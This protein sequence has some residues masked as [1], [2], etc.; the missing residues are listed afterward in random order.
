[1]I[2]GRTAEYRRPPRRVSRQSR[3][4]DSGLLGN[5]GGRKD[6]IAVDEINRLTWVAVGRP[7]TAWSAETTGTDT[8]TSREAR[9]VS[10]LPRVDGHRL[11]AEL[12]KTD[13]DLTV[14]ELM[15]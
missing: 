12:L 5:V 4:A 10:D 6:V 7:H 8:D 3:R 11:T 2:R 13:D 15:S 14:L 1:V 9:V